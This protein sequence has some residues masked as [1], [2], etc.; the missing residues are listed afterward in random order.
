M[1]AAKPTPKKPEAPAL[2]ELVTLSPAEWNPW[3]RFVDAAFEKME[4]GGQLEREL[5]APCPGCD[6]VVDER[7]AL[8]HACAFATL[9]RPRI[10]ATIP[11]RHTP[12][13]TRP[14]TFRRR[15]KPQLAKRPEAP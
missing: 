3:Y 4:G 9:V 2:G 5:T 6:E 13:L 8:T 10:G 12:D 7:A 11:I 1:K 14:M 15:A